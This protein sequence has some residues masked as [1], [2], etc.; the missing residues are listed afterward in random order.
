[1]FALSSVVIAQ[2]YKQHVVKQGESVTTIANM[3]QVTVEQIK[4]INND[5]DNLFPGLI[6]NIPV[7]AEQK[8]EPKKNETSP[9]PQKADRVEMI[10]G[11]YLLC[12][13]LRIRNGWITIEQKAVSD[14]S[15]RVPL[16][17]VV[18]I[19]YANGVVKRYKK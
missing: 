13:V 16:K 9:V 15:M 14:K 5:T 17:E 8:D 18:R 2:D 12:K 7:M 10:D 11:S 19:K 1:M 4:S 3:Y 6:L